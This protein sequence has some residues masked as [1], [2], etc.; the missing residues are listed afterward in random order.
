MR[1]VAAEKKQARRREKN[2][3]ARNEQ[4]RRERSQGATAGQPRKPTELTPAQARANRLAHE[5]KRVKGRLARLV[6]DVRR[7]FVRA[8]G[9]HASFELR[10]GDRGIEV[11]VKDGPTYAIVVNAF[12]EPDPR[13][14]LSLK[15]LLSH[16]D[17]W[18]LGG[19]MR[20]MPA[21]Q[22]H[23]SVAWAFA[24]EI[25]ACKPFVRCGDGTPLPVRSN[26]VD[27]PCPG[28]E[29]EPGT[30]SG[31]SA[32]EPGLGDCPACGGASDD[33]PGWGEPTGRSELDFEGKSIRD[34]KAQ[35]S[36]L[37]VVGYGRMTK[38]Q[39]QDAITD[40]VLGRDAT[41]GR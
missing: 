14:M 38:A 36:E 2:R 9:S 5:R 33:L 27:A 15:D 12:G 22:E 30:F 19:R 17:G 3:I 31:C 10:L 37:G 32:Q 24:R 29:V 8:L 35:A 1:T 21:G 13:I 34:L 16:G 28:F 41:D 4:R 23:L 26:V 6:P 7:T 18:L 25:L 20:P 11:A 39:L 40:R